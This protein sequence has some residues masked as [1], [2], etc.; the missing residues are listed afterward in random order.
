MVA[1]KQGPQAFA[2][3]MLVAMFFGLCFWLS[4]GFGLFNKC[5]DSRLALSLLN[6]LRCLLH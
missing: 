6:R 2:R 4:P 5:S 3:G 1:G